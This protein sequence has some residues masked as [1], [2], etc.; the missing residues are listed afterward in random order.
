MTA[1]PRA[2]LAAAVRHDPLFQRLEEMAQRLTGVVLLVFIRRGRR[3]AE[4]Y[5]SGRQAVLPEFCALMRSSPAGRRRC[6]TCRRLIALGAVCRGRVDCYSCHG[7]VSLVAAPAPTPAA[8]PAGTLVVTS[9]AFATARPADGWPQVRRYARGLPVDPAALAAAY[10]RLPQLGERELTLVREIVATAALILA[11]RPAQ[12]PGATSESGTTPP[13]PPPHR[14]PADLGSMLRGLRTESAPPGRHRGGVGLIEL[15]RAMVAR[16][17]ELPFSVAN[18]A[19]AARLTPNHLSL[20]FH[21]ESG[22]T[23]SS[24]LAAQRLAR[25]QRLL[26]DPRLQIAEV[27]ERT[28]FADASYFTRRFRRAFGVSPAAWRQ[29]GSASTAKSTADPLPRG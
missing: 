20:R 28:G 21:A 1:L 11:Q 4:L 23:F 25:A 8:E 6:E 5:A 14:L 27:A 15:I 16:N 26:R 22:E 12:G 2:S 9:C 29:L 10:R 17:P 18:I 3:I 24:F 7:G 13:T 19:R